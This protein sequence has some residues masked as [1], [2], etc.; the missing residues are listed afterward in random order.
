M[1]KSLLILAIIGTSFTAV[2]FTSCKALAKSA[3]KHWSKKQK[4]QFIA[5][6]KEGAFTKFGD[7]ANEVCS[8][9]ATIA[10]EKYP[11][12][13]DALEM[14]ALEIVKLAMDCK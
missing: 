2:T 9:V 10:E 7:K 5:K 4:K 11:K 6:C 12:I 8:C 1:K 13:E 3:V 14:S